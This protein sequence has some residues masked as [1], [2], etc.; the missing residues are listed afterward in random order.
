[1]KKTYGNLTVHSSGRVFL[2][3]GDEYPYFKKYRKNGTSDGYNYVRVRG[4]NKP[5]HRL[6]AQLFVSNPCASFKIVDHIN[7][8]RTDNRSSNLRW[9]N[10]WLNSINRDNTSSTKF[11]YDVRMWYGSFFLR[12]VE[13]MVGF[14]KTFRQSHLAVRAAKVEAFTRVHDG[15]IKNPS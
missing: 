6:V 13:H 10:N 9:A 3:S 4:H 11:D 12:G 14:F 8:I 15:L 7:R 1:M 2:K 5:V